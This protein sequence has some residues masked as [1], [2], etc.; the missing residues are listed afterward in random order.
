MSPTVV[1]RRS[2]IIDGDDDNFLAHQEVMRL[3]SH[4]A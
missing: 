3:A 1:H 4:L 2:K